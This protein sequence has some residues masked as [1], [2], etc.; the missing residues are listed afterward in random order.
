MKLKNI[1]N[2]TLVRL[3]QLAKEVHSFIEPEECILSA[4]TNVSDLLGT[5]L[6]SIMLLDEKS[7]ELLIRKATG[8]NGEIARNTRVKMGEGIAGWVA[9]TGKP[10]LIDDLSRSKRFKKY[11]KSDTKKYKTD[12]LLSVPLKIDNKVIGV[13]NVN[14]KKTKRIFTD[15]DLRVLTFISEH[16]SLAIQNALM[17]EKIKRLADMKLDFISDVS[18]ELKNPLA[19]IKDSMAVISEGLVGKVDN[20]KKHVLDIGMKN[21]DRLNRLLGSLLDLAKLE[22]GKAA[23]K[24][25]YFDIKELLNQSIDFI[26]STAKSKGISIKLNFSMRY[27]KIWADWDRITQ[28]V[29]NLLNNALKFTPKGGTITVQLKEKNKKAFVLVQDTG[30]GVRKQDLPKLFNKF[31]RLDI[32]KNKTKGTGLGLAI[33]KEI[34]GLHKGRIWVESKFHKGT[35]FNILLPKDLRKE[36]RA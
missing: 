14:N 19:V 28:V 13:L 1:P 33:C 21:I 12:S 36:E 15:K 29:S 9:K 26:R 32:T 31:E 6:G 20:K 5:E 8:F 4:L 7:K 17:Y 3:L 34:I 16:I 18:H 22:T 24:R 10:L 2:A 30:V 25:S 27:S 23:I 11:R 35:K